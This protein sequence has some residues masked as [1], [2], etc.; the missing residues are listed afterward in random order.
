MLYNDAIRRQYRTAEPTPIIEEAKKEN[1]TDNAYISRKFEKEFNTLFSELGKEKIDLE[2]CSMFLR[3]FGCL[4]C[5]ADEEL[6]P[7]LWAYLEGDT[8]NGVARD[9]LMVAIKAILRIPINVIAEAKFQQEGMLELTEKQCATLHK[10]FFNFYVNRRYTSSNDGQMEDK[11][12]QEEYSFKPQISK[13]TVELASVARGKIQGM[14]IETRFR[15][16]IIDRR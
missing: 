7:E 10:K 5:P 4:A 2:T 1:N 12:G 3:K 14:H 8:R 15:S 16:W 11:R 13:K 6:L 9:T